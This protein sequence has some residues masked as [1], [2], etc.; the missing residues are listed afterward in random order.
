MK[1]IFDK[2]VTLLRADCLIAFVNYIKDSTREFLFKFRNHEKVEGMKWIV[3]HEKPTSC[4]MTNTVL[5]D[6]SINK[7][8]YMYNWHNVDSGPQKTCNVNLPLYTVCDPPR[9]K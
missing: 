1:A 4:S 5:F 6:L 3:I 7:C 2:Y 8:K 9:T